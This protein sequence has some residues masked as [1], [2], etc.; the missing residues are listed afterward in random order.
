MVA[1]KFAWFP[2]E[3]SQM[4]GPASNEGFLSGNMTN[5]AEEKETKFALGDK[6][7]RYNL[8]GKTIFIFSIFPE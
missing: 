2:L 8:F 3:V 1:T 6:D 5:I 7:L 4:C